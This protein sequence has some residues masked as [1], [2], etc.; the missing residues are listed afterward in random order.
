MLLKLLLHLLCCLTAAEAC[1]QC[2]RR[3][4]N[5]HEDFILSASSVYNQIQLEKICDHA[6]VTYRETSKE[7][8]GVIGESTTLFS[9][10]I[11]SFSGHVFL[12]HY[13]VK[14]CIIDIGYLYYLGM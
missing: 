12:K 5:L 2:D 14:I 1:L 3:I 11:S 13:Q 7:R 6:Y 10:L 4:R 8:K 9:N